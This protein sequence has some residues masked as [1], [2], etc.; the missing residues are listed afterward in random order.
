MKMANGNDSVGLLVIDPTAPLPSLK[1][2][3]IVI[4]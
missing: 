2:S 1:M 4:S 3:M